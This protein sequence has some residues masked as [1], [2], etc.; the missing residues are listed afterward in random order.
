MNRLAVRPI[1]TGLLA[2]L[3][4]LVACW[5]LAPAR[6]GEQEDKD[7]KAR[8]L[9]KLDGDWSAAAATRDV[10]RVAS[11]YAEDAI[12][13]P[14]GEPAAVGRAGAKKVWGAYFAVPSFSISWKTTHAEV[15]GSGELGFTAGTY[16][17]AMEGPEGDRIVE[18]GKYL[19][20]WRLQKD[21]TWKAVH[22]MW[23]ANAG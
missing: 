10:E 14:P 6:A 11:F 16:E 21:G 8:A 4:V 13:Y 5:T 17:T 1:V 3:T 18:K 22:D 20:A 19:C 7:A 15:A 9:R 23:N 2:F 12:L